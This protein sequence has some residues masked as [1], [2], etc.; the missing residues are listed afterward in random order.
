MLSTSSKIIDKCR[1][2]SQVSEKELKVAETFYNGGKTNSVTGH[3]VEG[4]AIVLVFPGLEHVLDDACEMLKFF[5]EWPLSFVR[6][7]VFR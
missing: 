4:G 2:Q 1:H 7:D 3:F 5:D 6:G